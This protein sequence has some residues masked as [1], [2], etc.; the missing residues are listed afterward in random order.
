MIE[1][2]V[3]VD[4]PSMIEKACQA[5]SCTER[6]LA[7]WLG[8]SPRTLRHWRNREAPLYARLALVAV[9]RQFGSDRGGA[10][11]KSRQASDPK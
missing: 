2:S 9:I 10:T 4:T 3:P 8:L 5:R 1:P 6:E 11:R 7:L